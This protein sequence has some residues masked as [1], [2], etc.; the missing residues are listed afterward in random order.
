[1]LTLDALRKI[2]QKEG[3][4]ECDYYEFTTHRKISTNFYHF[5][6]ED[7]NIAINAQLGPDVDMATLVYTVGGREA[8]EQSS[9][10][11]LEKRKITVEAALKY[12]PWGPVETEMFEVKTEEELINAIKEAKKIARPRA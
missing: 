11:L 6:N 1:M 4:R 3:F 7:K 9:H 12:G 10:L 8:L 5:V 2:A